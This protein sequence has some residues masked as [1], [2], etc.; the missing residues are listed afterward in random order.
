M[1][2]VIV[3]AGDFIGEYEILTP[4]YVALSNGRRS[5]ELL[6]SLEEHH[7][8]L[9]AR[10]Q[11]DK[12]I[13]AL[14]AERPE[15]RAAWTRTVPGK[16]ERAF[17]VGVEELKKRARAAGGDAVVQLTHRASMRQPDVFLLELSGTA[18]R[19]A[20]EAPDDA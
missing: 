3:T 12:L 10:L 2:D 20:P 19:L 13:A 9:L 14:P 17:H 8:D 15:V 1:E 7:S 5:H 18:V 11:N 16:L 6:E 4:V